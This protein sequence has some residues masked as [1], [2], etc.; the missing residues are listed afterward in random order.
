MTAQVAERPE[1]DFAPKHVAELELELEPSDAQQARCVLRLELHQQV[2]LAVWPERA[3]K[4]GTEEAEA[5][6]AVLGA[7]GAELVVVDGDPSVN[8]MSQAS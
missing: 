7:E 6:D 4:D 2:D 1:I 8:S 3:V 5:A